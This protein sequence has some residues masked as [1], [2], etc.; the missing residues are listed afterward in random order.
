M[1][2]TAQEMVEWIQLSIR[3]LALTDMYSTMDQVYNDLAKRTGLSKS[4]VMKIQ[5]GQNT[6]PKASTIDS[7]V[8]AIK[9]INRKQA[10]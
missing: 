1:N 10:A 8:S 4:L 7:L 3:A 5:Q 2:S 9:A 6:N